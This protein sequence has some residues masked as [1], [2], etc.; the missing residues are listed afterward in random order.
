MT[1]SVEER[2][3]FAEMLREVLNS[4]RDGYVSSNVMIG[5]DHF[6]SATRSAPLPS[7][8]SPSSHD[9]VIRRGHGQLPYAVPLKGFIRENFDQAFRSERS[10]WLAEV[11]GKLFAHTCQGRLAGPFVSTSEGL[12]WVKKLVGPNG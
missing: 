7:S 6:E 12:A 3:R 4:M 10:V 2:Q 11:G 9:E 1:V 5:L 8:P